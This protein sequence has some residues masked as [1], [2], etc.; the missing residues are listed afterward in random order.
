[1]VKR[2]VVGGCS[3]STA[4]KVSVHQFP[5]DPLQRQ[6]WDAFVKTTR[7]DWK[8]GNQHSIICGAHF[9]APEDFVGWHMYQSGFKKQLNL[10][11]GAIP[12]IKPK[13]QS[14]APVRTDSGAGPSSADDQQVPVKRRKSGAVRKLTVARVG[15]F[16][17][18]L[19]TNDSD[20]LWL[21]I[22]NTTHFVSVDTLF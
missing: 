7:K 20:Q 12:S 9:K 10:V 22:V 17:L 8:T 19:N 13:K 1:M 11:P 18:S 14:V 16:D 3:N 2:C 4:D 6:K 15:H 21:K 5:K